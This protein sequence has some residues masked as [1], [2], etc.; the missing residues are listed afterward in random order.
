MGTRRPL[1]TAAILGATS[2]SPGKRYQGLDQ[3]PG[4][5]TIGKQIRGRPRSPSWHPQGTRRPLDT[6]AIL[7]ATSRSPGKRY[8]GLDQTPG[9]RTIGKPTVRRPLDTAAMSN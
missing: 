1:D 9:L 8:Q 7:G 5:R 2:R 3:T 6:A 4:L